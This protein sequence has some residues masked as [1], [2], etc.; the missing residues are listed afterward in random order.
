MTSLFLYKQRSPLASHSASL[1]IPRSLCVCALCL[2][3][4]WQGSSLAL[5]E[6]RS[7]TETVVPNQT[8]VEIALWAGIN[9]EL[10]SRLVLWRAAQI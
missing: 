9:S 4:E 7:V 3:R 5:R 8:R 1:S 10:A 6:R 2:I